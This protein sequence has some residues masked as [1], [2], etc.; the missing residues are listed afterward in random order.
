M[1]TR[2]L[3][4]SQVAAGREFAL[5]SVDAT[6]VIFKIG[7]GADPYEFFEKVGEHAVAVPQPRATYLAELL[8]E[9]LIKTVGSAT[10]SIG[11]RFVYKRVE[12]TEDGTAELYPAEVNDL[13]SATY[14]ALREFGLPR[15]FPNATDVVEALGRQ[16][17]ALV[18]DP[19]QNEVLDLDEF[20]MRYA[21]T[22]ARLLDTFTAHLSATNPALLKRLRIE[23]AD[24]Q[25]ARAAAGG[26]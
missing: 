17:S 20:T 21:R 18:L 2:N 8:N 15:R 14:T 23:F 1:T 10:K 16:A 12:L 22:F 5:R 19:G 13:D 7:S 24:Q 4:P 25:D 6:D 26:A 3:T 11:I 9:G